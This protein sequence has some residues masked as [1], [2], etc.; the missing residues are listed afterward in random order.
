MSAPDE[1]VWFE[2]LIL[3]RRAIA[4]FSDRP[5]ARAKVDRA[6]RLAAEA[7]SGYNV[8]PWRYL[9]LQ[10]AEQRERLSQAAFGQKKIAEAPVVFVALADSI[11]WREN[12]D[13]VFETRARLHGTDPDEVESAQS[14]AVS[15]IE[16]QP[17]EV[18]LTRQVMIGFT[19]L[20]LACESLGLNTAPMEG[21]D[22][23][24]VRSAFKLPST[25]TVVALLA[26]GYATKVPPHPGRLAIE[27][28]SFDEEYGV[29]WLR[30]GLEA[31]PAGEAPSGE[32][33]V[34]EKKLRGIFW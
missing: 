12:L 22:P 5:V 24:A 7:P 6:L 17:M 11:G 33:A 18:W 31:S 4:Q 8:Q 23:K 27:Q 13:E 25:T 28:T 2:Q 9:V 20:M 29:P 21:F 15:F 10:G 19:Y 3:R 32:H 34:S 26:A 30:P 1:S 16:T 14:A